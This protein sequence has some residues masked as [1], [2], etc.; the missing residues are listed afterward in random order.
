MLFT[1]T[2]LHSKFSKNEA[3]KTFVPELSPRTLLQRRL[4]YQ[5]AQS[6]CAAEIICWACDEAVKLRCPYN[7]LTAWAQPRTDL[8]Q[9]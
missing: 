1:I 9:L 5:L 3:K 2:I 4:P 6:N 8:P 7:L